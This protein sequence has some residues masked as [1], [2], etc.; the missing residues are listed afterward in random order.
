MGLQSLPVG[1]GPPPDA[2]HLLGVDEAGRGPV[3]GPLVVAGLAV[4]AKGGEEHLRAMRV[5][6]SKKL[7]VARRERLYHELVSFPYA[8]IE[9]PAEDIDALRTSASMNVL[10]ARLFASVVSALVG[11]LGEGARVAVYLDAVDTDE[12]VFARH[13]RSALAGDPLATRVVQVVSRHEADDTF[14]VV[15]AASI[16]AKGRREEAVA[17][18]REELGVDIGSG[19]PGDRRTIAFLEKWISE[20]GCLPPHTRTSW[21]TAQRLTGRRDAASSSLDDFGD[22]GGFGIDDGG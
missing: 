11:K 17:R 15:S 13:F 8:V 7:Q 9:V 20:K 12:L 1:D 21:R 22:E 2:T 6:D 4:P 19:Y 14:P 16:V 5:R 3:M 10:E 18:I